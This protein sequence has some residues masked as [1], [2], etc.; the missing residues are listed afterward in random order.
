MSM[1]T[2]TAGVAPL[3][4]DRPTREMSIEIGREART[5]VPRNLHAHWEEPPDRGDPIAMLEGQNATRLPWLVPLRH[6]RMGVSAFTFF[7]GSA[8]IMA[9][10]LAGSPTSGSDRPARRR[11]PPLELRRVR[12]AGP[13][14]RR[15]RQ[16]LRR[17]P[18]GPMGMGPEAPRRQRADRRAAPGVQTRRTPVARPSPSSR[19]TATRWPSSPSSGT[20]TPGTD[21]NTSTI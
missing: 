21:R 4:V 15:R 17:D 1:Q 5:H 7:R 9:G 2:E 8:I 20:S 14:A 11:R 13:T 6:A 16:R 10:D 3:D 18:A 19:R 12:I